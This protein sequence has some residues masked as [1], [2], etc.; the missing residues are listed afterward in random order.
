M[1]GLPLQPEPQRASI[2]PVNTDDPV[3]PAP[4]RSNGDATGCPSVEMTHCQSLS[5]QREFICALYIC[6]DGAR[7]NGFMSPGCHLGFSVQYGDLYSKE[8]ITPGL[9]PG[10][11][12]T[13]DD[14][15]THD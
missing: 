11:R 12:Y 2:L 13:K 7:F 1:H 8:T 15:S 9:D 3:V 4:P 6:I 14:I 10:C 5:L